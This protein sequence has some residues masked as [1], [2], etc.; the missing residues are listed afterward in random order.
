MWDSRYDNEEYVYGTLP[1][2][3]LKVSIDHL[4]P[5]GELLCL[6]EGEG[7]N[8][9]WLAEQGFNVTAV[10]SSPIGLKKAQN[11]ASQ[12]GVSITTIVA[13][14]AQYELGANRW[15]GVIS[16]F[17]HLPPTLRE[18]LHRAIPASLKPEGILILEG[19]HPRQLEYKTGGP[20]TAELMITEQQLRDELNPLQILHCQE[21]DREIMEGS[22]H[23]GLGAVVQF[24]GK[25]IPQKS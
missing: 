5:G 15:D 24:I 10:D 23:H 20:P 17:C 8:S 4:K 3:F 22:L 16:I 14:L 2:D 13:D 1:N 9:V 7:R 12:R 11:L 21:L 18:N 6:A 19:Y 25:K